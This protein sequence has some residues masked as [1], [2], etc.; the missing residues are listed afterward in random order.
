[1]REERRRVKLTHNTIAK[2]LTPLILAGLRLQ[3]VMRVLP[4]TEKI[5]RYVSV[6]SGNERRESLDLLC[7]IDM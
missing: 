4:C 7:S 2:D 3:T 6:K 1:M 5:T